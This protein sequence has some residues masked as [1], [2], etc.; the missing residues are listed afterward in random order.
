MPKKLSKKEEL[1]RERLDIHENRD[2]LE[3]PQR[4]GY[5][6]RVVTES[7]VEKRLRYGWTHVEENVSLGDDTDN[8]STGS[9][10]T[11]VTGTDEFHKPVMCYLMEIPTEKYEMDQDIKQE[12]N[13][14]IM[15]SINKGDERIGTF[16]QLKGSN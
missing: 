5:I 3:A 8:V 12:E 15:L 10:T 2:V 14:K 16:S 11:V 4:E 6:R 1:R 9:G 13:D 7:N